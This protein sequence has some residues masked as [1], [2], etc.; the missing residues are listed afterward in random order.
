MKVLGIYQ[1]IEVWPKTSREATISVA[2]ETTNMVGMRRSRQSLADR[3]GARIAALRQTRQWTQAHLA[4][5]V[6][7]D[8]ETISR[9]ERGAT[10]PSLTTLEQIGKSLQVGMGDL[11][12]HTDV[13]PGDQALAVSAWL[14][15]LDQH[16]RAFVLDMVKRTCD[17][18]RNP[19]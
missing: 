4:E 9:F 12:A 13:T 8:T 16:H 5:L 11:L 6:G 3:L 7:V 19:M 18:L 17:H 15:G 2:R 14:D 1:Q 10:L